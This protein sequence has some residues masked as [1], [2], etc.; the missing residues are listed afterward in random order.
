MI[1][2]DNA[3]AFGSFFLGGFEC[4]SHRRSDG[5]RLDLLASTGH[6]RLAGK[7]YR[8]LSQHGVRAVRDGLRWHLIET[9]P[10]RYEW[11]SFLPML[12]AA[13]AAGTRVIWD[14]CHYGWPDDLDIWSPAF[15][16]RFAQ[17]SAAAARVVMAESEDVPVYCPVN[18]MSFWAWAGGEVGR[19]NPCAH[20]RGVELKRQLVRATIAAIDAIRAVDPRARFIT[21]EP[22]IHVEAGL[23]DE[24]HVRRAHAYRQTQFEALDI[25]SGAKEPEIGER[26]NTS[27]SSV[28]TTIP[29][30]NGIMAARRSPWAIMPTDPCTKCWPRRMGATVVRSSSP[31]PARKGPAGLPGS[32]MSARKCT[33]LWMPAFPSRGSASTRSPTI[34]D[35]TTRGSAVWVSCPSRMRKVNARS[36][37]ASPA[38]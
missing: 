12:R 22:L 25:L 4:S 26:P 36:A 10:S 33:L 1:S 19:F 3:S 35:G 37:R 8:L 30:T 13:N 18:E 7:D 23:G 27:I 16:D 11:D 31:R 9:A 14:L 20:G 21:A 15:I 28:S 2:L 38:N 17:F 24:E 6:D 32:I 5:R 29:T 34:L